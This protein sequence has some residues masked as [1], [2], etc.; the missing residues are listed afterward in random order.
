MTVQGYQPDR[1]LPGLLAGDR[2]SL[3]RV[4]RLLDAHTGSHAEV[5]TA[6]PGLLLACAEVPGVAE[7]A[8][9][10][11]PRVLLVADL[12]ARAAEMGS[13]QVFYVL[14]SD[15]CDRRPIFS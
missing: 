7:A 12:L 5:R 2:T 6:R 14:A 3:E 15:E 13:L 11:G 8:D 1:A 10:T 4:L 9:L